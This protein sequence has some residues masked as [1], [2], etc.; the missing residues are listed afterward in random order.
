MRENEN[1]IIDVNNI[2]GIKFFFIDRLFLV[3]R[4]FTILSPDIVITKGMTS[5]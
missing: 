5:C 3:D 4:D 2:P 1:S